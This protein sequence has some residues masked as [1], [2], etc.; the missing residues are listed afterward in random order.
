MDD[1]VKLTGE[2]RELLSTIVRKW[3][4][5]LQPLLADLDRRRLTTTEREAL[6]G[7]LAKELVAAGLDQSDEPTEYGLE[8]DGVIGRLMYF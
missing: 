5:E 7:A 8:L 6:R 2:E 1:L 4:P 3:S